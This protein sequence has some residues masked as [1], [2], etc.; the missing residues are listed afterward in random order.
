MILV[1]CT[2]HLYIPVTLSIIQHE[3]GLYAIYTDRE[4]IYKFF[5]KMYPKY[6][7]FLLERDKPKNCFYA[8]L[9]YARNLK[10]S[11]HR[12]FDCKQ[13]D[14]LY[15]F[16]EGFCQ[17]AN[18][19]IIHLHKT[20]NT[21]CF[22]IPVERTFNPDVK[23][24]ERHSLKLWIM[25]FR[26]LV[27]WKYW[28]HFYVYMNYLYPVMDQSFFRCIQSKELSYDLKTV[29][30]LL[31]IDKHLLGKDRYPEDCVVWLEN[32]LR[33]F[34]VKWSEKS[35]KRFLNQLIEVFPIERFFF[36]G[37]P[38]LET[39]YGIENQ[40]KEIPAFIPGNLLLKRFSVY[41]GVVSDLLF[42]A[43]NVGTP[44]ISTLY[45]I[46]MDDDDREMLVN[47][48]RKRNDKIMFPK[49]IQEL[50]KYLCVNK[51]EEV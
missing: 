6:E 48:L 17:E 49:S 33:L 16:H 14:K 47:Y 15:F 40:M 20:Q 43:A 22:Y 36:K 13:I 7:V 46:E 29:D 18:W 39:K 2:S 44:T 25:K 3:K 38:D 12:F 26:I 51:T 34:E 10:T 9:T 28:C 21:E 50:K 1:F 42:E 19:L 27:N 45:L 32:T 24:E 11:M 35:Y 4:S 8:I 37:H 23:W 5:G 31:E 41:V 30:I